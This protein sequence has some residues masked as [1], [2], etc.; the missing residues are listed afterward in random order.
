MTRPN[1]LLV[2]ADQLAP[3]FT[4]TYGHPVVSTPNLDSLAERGARF[5]AFYCHSPL[6]A[7]ARFT[8]LAGRS[9]SSIGAWDNAAEFPASVPTLAHHL[10]GAGYR[11]VLTGKMHFVGPDQMHG[12]EERLT[13]DIYPADFAWTP[14]WGAADRRI[15][16]W[17]HNMD[18]L[19]EA[20]QAVTTHQIDYDEEV[21]YT[22]RRKL[23]DLARDR[24]G[25]PFFLVASFIHPHDP[26]VA[27]PEWWNRY[28]EAAI[29]L[30]DPID[31]ADLDDHS[32]R[33][34]AG[35]QADTVGFTEAQARAARR[36]YYANT[37]YVDD[38]L[39]RLLDTLVETGL[40]DSTVVIFTSDHGDMLGDRGLWYKMTF[41]E[42]SARVPL[43]IAGPG[44]AHRTV[45]NVASHLDLLPTILDVATDGGDWRRTAPDVEGR[46]LWPLASG[47][48]DDVSET[49]GEY[50]AE[51]TSH[52][53][54]MIRRDHF[55]YIHCDTDP[56]L[57]YDLDTDPLERTDLAGRPAYA[58]IADGF[59]AEVR[60]RWD[61]EAIRG[62]VLASQRARHA[63][64]RA[65]EHTVGGRS[66]DHLPANDVANQYVRNHQDVVDAA[67]RSRL[68]VTTERS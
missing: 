67:L 25:R 68:R 16:K 32:L 2:M 1:V 59:A 17:Y 28:D 4:A 14:D 6:C 65:T 19:A 23:H 9:V 34:R 62:R 39:G 61:S 42:R 56:P 46:S 43:V 36:G 7:P 45:P 60:A 20:G 55:K 44:V 50:T 64:H 63:I 57:L 10:Q 29:D 22:A 37:S 35:I 52:P 58:E 48:D 5:D 12:F 3:H 31:P 11:T 33:V 13:T 38:W 15:D 18:P 53:M 49:T 26:Y 21:G 27:R 66:W 41:F 51:M 8:M 24:D 30:P 47:D 40:A 54:F